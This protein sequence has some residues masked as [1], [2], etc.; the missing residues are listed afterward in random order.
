[1]PLPFW[2]SRHVISKERHFPIGDEERSDGGGRQDSALKLKGATQSSHENYV[3]IEKGRCSR[4]CESVR[5]R[6][7][8]FFSESGFK[9]YRRDIIIFPWASWSWKRNAGKITLLKKR[10]SCHISTGEMLR[11][12]VAKG[13]ELGGRVKSVLDAGQLVSDDLM[14]ELVKQ[15]IKDKDCEKGLSL[16]VS[17]ANCCP[18]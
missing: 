6:D 12:A 8:K 7:R 5:Q 3:Y 15:R 16:M 10:A 4:M 13:N 17:L 2:P 11:A 9:A 1:M 18:S 14:I